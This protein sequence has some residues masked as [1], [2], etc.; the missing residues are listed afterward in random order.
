MF[1][2]GDYGGGYQS[3]IGALQLA[4]EV[5]RANGAGL[6][7]GTTAMFIKSS[8]NVLIGTT[9]DSGFKLDVNGTGRFS[10]NLSAVF[11][12]NSNTPYIRFDESSIAKFFIGQRSI[13][14]GDGGTGYDLYTTSG[15]D[16][17]FYIGGSSTSR[18]TLA[19]TGA[20]TFETT[21]AISA[22]FN[23]TNAS[24]GYIGFRRSGNSIGYLGN[25]AQL[26]IGTLNAL[27]L[28]ADNNLFLTTTSGTLSILSTGNVGIGTNTP[29]AKL[30]VSNVPTSFFGII[31]TTGNSAGAVKHFRVHKPGYVEYAIGI[32]ADNSFS[33]FF[34][35]DIVI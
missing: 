15:N 23:S 1:G 17:R 8:G 12:S 31:E 32:L 27:E 21:S 5:N 18:L 26:G 7:T 20:A 24:G 22:I 30:Q 25:S 28:R 6:D 4:F 16:L 19:T 2:L 3:R 13:I 33:N 34:S 9:T 10:G 11:N 14:S 35:L 29:S